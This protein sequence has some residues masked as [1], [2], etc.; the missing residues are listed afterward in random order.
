MN[1]LVGG[2]GFE[3]VAD[4]RDCFDVQSTIRVGGNSV[5]AS[6]SVDTWHEDEMALVCQ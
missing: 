4:E 5:G 6:T 3:C 2:V 1:E